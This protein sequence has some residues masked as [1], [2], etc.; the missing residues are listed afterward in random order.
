MTHNTHI[1]TPYAG[2]SLYSYRLMEVLSA[3]SIP[4]IIADDWVLP[5]R[6]TLVEWGRGTNNNIGGCGVIIPEH[7]LRRQAQNNATTTGNN[8]SSTNNNKKNNVITEYLDKISNEERCQMR[9]KCFHVYETYM[10][11][12]TGVIVGIIE[13]LENEVIEN[14]EYWFDSSYYFNRNGYEDGYDSTIYNIQTKYE[15]Y[16]WGELDVIVQDAA[17]ILGY[18]Q[19]LWNHIGD[20]SLFSESRSI[21]TEFELLFNVVDY[22]ELTKEQSDAAILLGYTTESKWKLASQHI[23][24][25]M[26]WK[27][28]KN[29]DDADIIITTDQQQQ[30]QQYYDDDD[31]DN[32][33][34]QHDDKLRYDDDDDDDRR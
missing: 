24:N 22:N 21:T 14:D 23:K 7:E 26:I 2:D 16:Y 4:I 5:F 8:N 15:R 31:N 33:H 34:N 13:T 3:G 30:Q 25:I 17:R 18:T 20:Y 28:S 10:K 9:K 1:Y 27:Q 11:N 29:D 6:S 32:Q 12:D 19:H